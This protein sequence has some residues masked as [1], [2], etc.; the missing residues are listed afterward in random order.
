MGDACDTDDDDDGMEDGDD[1]CPEIFEPGRIDLDQNGIG[2]RCDPDE[3]FA[4]SGEATGLIP[5][6]F[7]FPDLSSPVQIPIFPCFQDGCPDWLPEDFHAEVELNSE[8]PFPARIID[9]R[10]FTVSR[11]QLDREHLLRFR[12][13]TS[14]HYRAPVAAPPSSDFGPVGTTNRPAFEG[15]RYYLMMH[16]TEQTQLGRDYAV[17]IQVRSGVGDL[18]PPTFLSVPASMAVQ[19]SSRMGSAVSYPPPVARDNLDIT[20]QLVCSPASGSLFPL[21]TS[22]VTCTASDTAGN[23]RTHSFTVTVQDTIAPIVQSVEIKPLRIRRTRADSLITLQ[24]ADAGS[25]EFLEQTLAGAAPAIE[26]LD[27]GRDS[28]LGTRDDMPIAVD[29]TYN[30]ALQILSAT[31]RHNLTLNDMYQLRLSATRVSD[32]SGNLLDG[33]N[34][35][36]PGDD[37]VMQFALGTRI[38]VTDSDGDK[39]TIT[40]SRG[41]LLEFIRTPDR[42]NGTLRV[43][44]ATARSQLGGEV[45]KPRGKADGRL[46]VDSVFGAAGIDNRMP[47]CSPSRPRNCF[48]VHAIEATVVDLLLESGELLRSNKWIT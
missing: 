42:V 29:V 7:S 3:A 9:D 10:G 44:E 27:A 38:A 15:R 1:P 18:T 40:L 33:N 21:G 24:M 2:L 13:A 39:G 8:L 22:E 28:R 35:G 34:D 12:P 4:L 47:V 6:R 26:L 23:L 37:F 48:E 17:Q 19:L 16:P 43:L 5:G 46:A 20:I 41:G 36:V 30:P 31:P 14:H 25:I 11:G 45:R 32:T